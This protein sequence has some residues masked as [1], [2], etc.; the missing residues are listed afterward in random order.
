MV[1]FLIKRPI[2]VSMTFLGVLLLG[3]VAASYLPV[4]LVPDVNIP[5]ITVSV[6]APNYSARQLENSV[7]TPLRTSLMQ[8]NKLRDIRTESRNGSGLV[9]LEFEY[10]TNTDLAYI[11]INEHID[12]AMHILPADVARPA[13]IKASASDIPVF[14]LNVCLT[15]GIANEINLNNFYPHLSKNYY[16]EADPN[17]HPASKT[18]H[19]PQKNTNGHELF[20]TLTTCSNG[21]SAKRFG[22]LS[23]FVDEVIRRRLEQIPQ[24]AM[25]DISGRTFSEIIIEPDM[26]KLLALNLPLSKIESAIIA[27]NKSFGNILLRDMQYRYSIRF[28]NRLFDA[29][30]IGELYVKHEGRLWQIK[31]LCNIETRQQPDEG[32]VYTGNRR[33]ITIAIIK[34]ADARMQ[35]LK[36]SLHTMISHFETDY[37]QLEFQ[38]YRD[39]TALLDN[40]MSNLKQT[41]VTGAIL[42]FLVMFVFLRDPRTPWLVIFSVPAALIVSMLCFHIIGISLNVVSLS[43]LVLCVGMMIDNAIIVTD[44]ITRHHQNGKNLEHA[45]ADGTNEVFRPLLS[46]VLTTCSV[47]IPLIFLGG[48][49]GALFF[50]QAMAVTI[51][52]SVSLVIAT[53]LLPVYYHA[54]WKTASQHKKIRYIKRAEPVYFKWYKAG[55]RFALKRQPAIWIAAVLLIA[56]MTIMLFMTEKER[57][58]AIERD[59]ATLY[60]DWNENINVEENLRRT[61]LLIAELSEPVFSTVFAGRQ[62][63]MFENIN[64]S[65]QQSMVYLNTTGPSALAEIMEQFGDFL[66]SRYPLAIY[67]FRDD[68]NLFDHL[69]ADHQAPLQIRLHPVGVITNQLPQHL[70]ETTLML[71]DSLPGRSFEAIPTQQSIVLMAD[72]QMLALHNVSY[73]A[74]QQKLTRLFS[75]HQVSRLM[76]N[77]TGIPIKISSKP[78]SLE[79]ILHSETIS[80]RKG[81]EIP[82]K[83]LIK[84]STRAELQGIVAGL[85]GEYYPLETDADARELSQLTGTIRELLAGEGLF[86]ASFAG[87][88]YARMELARELRLIGLVAFALLFFILA[89]Q[90]ESLKLPAII[91]LEIPIAM[92]GALFL[93]LVSRET[94]NLMSMTGMVVM[95]GIIIN[96][97]ILKIDTINKLLSRGLPLVSALIKAGHYRLKPILMTSI[98]TICALLPFMFIE[99][100]GGDLQKPLALSVIGG[101]GLGT[102]VSLFF[103]PVCYHCLSEKKK[104]FRN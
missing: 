52:L 59:A 55:F 11:E 90:F 48:L 20:K 83:T 1:A 71:K 97:S 80:N 78:V 65:Q 25:A 46:S 17:Y 91:L 31:D 26:K 104:W 64:N 53:T 10:G 40:T 35:D 30:D 54:L 16:P 41:I 15:D 66:H 94:L 7:I 89:A 86:E 43:G 4:S 68:G 102:L 60:I 58:P 101:L 18:N 93:L 95:T 77:K 96:D 29:D 13:V 69:F 23:G 5:R 38:I 56:G 92:S 2:A 100:L 32:M 12:R 79:K 74:M 3:I 45:C 47:F 87:S 9:N 57:L 98:T 42:A 62:Q 88:I 37:P 34:Q 63:F 73:N 51:G 39:Q 14:Y 84:R 36:K 6:S 103:I 22:E 19:H 67:R 76:D 44:N 27:N 81:A 75:D 72:L 33:T 21:F 50:D 70:H 99:G 28:G 49:P 61:K 24:V 85:R 82:L 8:A